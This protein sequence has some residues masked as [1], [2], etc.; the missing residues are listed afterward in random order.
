MS[1]SKLTMAA[2]CATMLTGFS[3]KADDNKFY[4]QLNG[5]A[6]FGL[7]PKDD[8]GTKKAGTSGLV[9]LEAG[10][11]I[12]E[13]FRTSVSLDY[14]TKFSFSDKSDIDEENEKT[15]TKWKI[16]SLVAMVNVY[17]DVMELNGFTPYV[18]L[19]AGI[20]R[21]KVNG[22]QD[23]TTIKANVD[24]TQGFSV[25]T[26]NKTNFAYKVGLGTRYSFDQN[27]ALDVRYQ[28]ADLGKIKTATNARFDEANNGKLR[29]HEFLV[30][31]AYKF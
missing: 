30:G 1:L 18:T 19:G 5:G 31:I 2:L 10:Y 16:K 11:Q 3:A 21:N 14:L 6:A 23:C 9:G 26:G 27:I 13:Q 17:Y 24:H 4:V 25:P 7:A 20:A 28:F 8:F 12:T 22:Y 29:A 15:D